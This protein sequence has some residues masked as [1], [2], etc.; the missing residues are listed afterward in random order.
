MPSSL[1]ASEHRLALEQTFCLVMFRKCILDL[2]ASFQL[3]EYSQK[4]RNNY[5]CCLMGT[6]F[7]GVLT[8]QM[9]N[10]W[11]G[12]QKQILPVI[13]NLTFS[14]LCMCVFTYLCTASRNLY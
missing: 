9:S 7:I 1:H 6:R 12:H 4:Y 5:V 13:V 10:R 14:Q 2:A 8:S 3:S 11:V